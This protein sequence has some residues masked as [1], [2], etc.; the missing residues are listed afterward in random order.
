L[1]QLSTITH[2]II[3]AAIEVHRNL[4]PGLPEV[5]YERAMCIEFNLRSVK[6]EQQVSAD[7]V[8][9]GHRIGHYRID[10][11]VEDA[12]V[13]EVKSVTA[14]GPV[15]EGQVLTYLKLTG[16]RLGLLLNF[17]ERLLTDGVRRFVL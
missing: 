13:L 11:V 7:A 3:G 2:Q 14:V 12:V 10:F 6:Y 1:D 17:H 15:F 16:K 4:G 5:V 9:K 8:Y